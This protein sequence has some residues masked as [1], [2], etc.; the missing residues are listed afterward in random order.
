MRPGLTGG[1]ATP[2]DTVTNVDSVLTSK[3]NSGCFKPRSNGIRLL[4]LK[5]HSSFVGMDFR[6]QSRS[7]ETVTADCRDPER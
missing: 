4:F 6:E 1:P 2:I 5:A 3:A 7:G